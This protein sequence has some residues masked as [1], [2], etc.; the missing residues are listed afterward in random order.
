MIWGQD[1]SCGIGFDFQE[2]SLWGGY[3]DIESRRYT[4]DTGSMGQGNGTGRTEGSSKTGFH[5]HYS[6]G[7]FDLGMKEMQLT[8]AKRGEK[9]GNFQSFGKGDLSL[10]REQRVLGVMAGVIPKA[11][12]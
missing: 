8:D 2:M 3:D 4:D 5:L 10:W 6:I 11:G 9:L 1:R 7:L 12:H